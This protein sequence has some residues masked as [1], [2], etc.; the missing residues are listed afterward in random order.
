VDG[1]QYVDSSGVLE[2]VDNE[3]RKKHLEEQIRLSH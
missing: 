1:V 3:Y 2:A